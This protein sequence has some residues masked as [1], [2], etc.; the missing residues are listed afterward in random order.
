MVVTYCIS[1]LGDFSVQTFEDHQGP[2]AKWAPILLETKNTKERTTV[3]NP[4]LCVEDFDRGS[5]I[6][7][8]LVMDLRGCGILCCGFG[9]SV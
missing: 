8:V 6:S 3:V 9:Y 2:F 7:L 4:Y 1:F 5:N